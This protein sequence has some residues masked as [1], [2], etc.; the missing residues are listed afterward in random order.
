V[1]FLEAA[2]L[3]FKNGFDFK[4]RASQAEYWYFLLA[5]FTIQTLT[6]LL[7]DPALN[8]RL[9]TLYLFA[10]Q[11]TFMSWNLAP[12]HGQLTTANPVEGVL[13]MLLAIPLLSVTARRLRDAG[14]SLINLFWLLLPGLGLVVIFFKCANPSFDDLKFVGT[15]EPKLSDRL[16]WIVGIV[17]LIALN[18]ILLQ[19]QVGTCYDYTSESGATSICTSTPMLGLFS[20]AVLPALSLVAIGYFIYRAARRDSGR[21]S[22]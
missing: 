9:V 3:G 14:K 7:T 6:S 11:N 17:I 15:T 12:S 4:G 2:A 19:F 13:L 5:A 16:S 20:T 18:L 22:K 21:V 1:N 8:D 10:P